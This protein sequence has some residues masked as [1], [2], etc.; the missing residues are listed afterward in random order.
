MKQARK[1]CRLKG[2]DGQ[3]PSSVNKIKCIYAAFQPKTEQE[4]LETNKAGNALYLLIII[5]GNL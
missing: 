2:H 5:H 4:A 3:P 1:H